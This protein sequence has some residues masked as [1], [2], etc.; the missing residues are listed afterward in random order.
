MAL[1]RGIWVVIALIVFAVFV[2]AMGM[3]LLFSAFGREPQVASGSTLVLRVGGDMA[4]MEPGG[5]FGPFMEATPTV[6]SVVETLRKAKADSRITSVI[7]K[8]TGQAA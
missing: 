6:R 7:L 2:S 5:L 1:R 4:E 3:L 8:P